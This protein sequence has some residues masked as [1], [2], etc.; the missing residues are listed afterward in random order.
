VITARTREAPKDAQERRSDVQQDY[1]S[2]VARELSEA[3]RL[4]LEHAPLLL[5]DVAAE[6]RRR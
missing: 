4:V 3:T 6:L 1:V 5:Q 2:V